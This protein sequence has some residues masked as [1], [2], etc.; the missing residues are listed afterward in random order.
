[1][2]MTSPT[3][4]ISLMT[5]RPMRVMPRILGL[6]A[7]GREQALVV[8]GELHE[9]DAERV[10]DLD[11]ADIVL[12]RRRILRA[13][14]DR[15]PAFAARADDVGRGAAMEDQPGKRSKRRFQSLDIGDRLAK[16]LVIGDRRMNRVMPASRICRKIVSDQLQYCRPSITGRGGMSI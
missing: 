3:R 12:D 4:F 16:V 13:E 11:E 2:S 10:A 7:A 5:S 14:K 15:G 9:A 1:M 8:V 6:V